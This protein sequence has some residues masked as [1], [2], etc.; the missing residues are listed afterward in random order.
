MQYDFSHNSE[1]LLEV[2]SEVESN[3]GETVERLSSALGHIQVQDVMRQRMGHVQE[4]LGDMRE[5]LQELAG[6][7]GDAEWDGV[8]T[9][10]FKEILESHL[11]QYRMAS[12]TETHLAVSGGQA[13]STSSGP[14]IELF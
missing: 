2:I 10:T 14:A 3:Y 12:Q 8:L 13:Q 11:G 9:R 5:H 6:L 7:A 4:A 1:L